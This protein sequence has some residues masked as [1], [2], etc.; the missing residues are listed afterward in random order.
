[1]KKTQVLVALALILCCGSVFAD[2]DAEKSIRASVKAMMAGIAAGDADRAVAMYASDGSFM[3]PN[4]P[5]A[6]GIDAIRKWFGGMLSAGKVNLAI[7]IDDVL[8]S[9]DLAV[10]RGTWELNLLPTG[11]TTAVTDHGK[12]IVV[13]QKRDGK[14]LAVNDIFNSDVP[15][16]KKAD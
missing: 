3:P 5:A 2:D 4:E 1:M 9:G 13:W 12:Y 6:K 11:A 16:P 8:A 7:N 15:L 14:W 10:E